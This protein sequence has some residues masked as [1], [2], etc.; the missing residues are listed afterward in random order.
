MNETTPNFW[1][2]LFSGVG[3][4]VMHRLHVQP[5]VRYPEQ[6]GL[7]FLPGQNLAETHFPTANSG[8]AAV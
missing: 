8:P 3:A 5:F 7:N 2:L 6:S 1:Y 4:P